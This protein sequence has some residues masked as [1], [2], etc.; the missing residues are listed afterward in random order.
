MG[1]TRRRRGALIGL[2]NVAVH[3][4]LPGWQARRDCEIVAATDASPAREADCRTR[5]PAAR[6][7]DSVESLLAREALDFVDI[8]TP[9]SSLATLIEAALARGLHVLCEKPLVGAPDELARL[10]GLARS[11]GVVLHTVHNWHHAPLVRATDAV[12][13]AGHIGEVREVSWQTLR[14]QPAAA[15]GLAWRVDPAIAGG[16]VL[17]DHGW[18]VSY[19]IPRWVG[20]APVAVSARLETR[21]HHRFAVEDTATVRLHFARATADVLLTWAADT[22]ENRVRVTGTAGRLEIEGDT[23][24]V[25]AQGREERRQCPPPLSDG[26]QHP[27]WFTAVADEFLAR[28]D[29]AGGRAPS[30]NL[31]EAAVCVAIECGARESSRRGGERLALTARPSSPVRAGAAG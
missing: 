13:R 28:L 23:L 30:P 8:C 14:T 7:H 21:R 3:G 27:D 6:W 22:R 26:S 11:A 31:D 20:E 9:P 19:V 24:V 4:H 12:I 10:A 2:G 15:A 29:T 16:G 17:T 18:H 1:E 5:L 25:T